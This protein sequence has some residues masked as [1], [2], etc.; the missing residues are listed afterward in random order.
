MRCGLN[1]MVHIRQVTRDLAH[2]ECFV[3]GSFCRA[4]RESLSSAQGRCSWKGNKR[5]MEMKR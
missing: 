2:S 1:K 3:D 4:Y 5:S